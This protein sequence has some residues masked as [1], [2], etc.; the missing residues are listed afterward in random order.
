MKLR[1]I[2]SPLDR[3]DKA[4]LI[5]KVDKRGMFKVIKPSLCKKAIT[6]IK[7]VFKK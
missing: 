2:D 7:N 4:S 5:I 1:D 3:L 6:Y